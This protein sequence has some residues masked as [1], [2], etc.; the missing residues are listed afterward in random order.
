MYFYPITERYEKKMR[1]ILKEYIPLVIVS[2]FGVLMIAIL[3]YFGISNGDY[4][5]EFRKVH[6]GTVTDKI[7]IDDTR[8]EYQL[9]IT[10]KFK[11]DG[12]TRTELETINVKRDIYVSYD[13]GDTFDKHNPVLKESEENQC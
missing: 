12:K 8:N 5:K 4:D 13:I 11:Y 10:Y 6:V 2:A 3:L 1:E 9:E 7:M